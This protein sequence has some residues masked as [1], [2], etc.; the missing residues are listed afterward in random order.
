[1]KCP[2]RNGDIVRIF[3]ERV[4][5]FWIVPMINCWKL[6]KRASWKRIRIVGWSRIGSW[7]RIIFLGRVFT[8]QGGCLCFYFWGSR[9]GRG[10][11]FRDERTDLGRATP[12]ENGAD[13]WTSWRRIR[14]RSFCNKIPGISTIIPRLR[15]CRVFL[16]KMKLVDSGVGIGLGQRMR[17]R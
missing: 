10:L 15:F 1:M 7:H 2:L 9:W 8:F 4:I 13:H 11:W 14:R 17:R 16:P 6:T 12:L 5:R 3:A